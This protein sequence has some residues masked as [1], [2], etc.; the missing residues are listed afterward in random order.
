MSFLAI[1]DVLNFDFC[2]FEQLASPN[3]TKNAKNDIFGLF[4]FAKI[5]FNVKSEWQ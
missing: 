3:F 5:W 2:K 1:L 4:E